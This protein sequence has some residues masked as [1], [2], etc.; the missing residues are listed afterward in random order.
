MKIITYLTQNLD[1]YCKHWDLS[2]ASDRKLFRT[3]ATEKLVKFTKQT[4]KLES[5]LA[6]FLVVSW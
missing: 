6:Y 5:T 4:N 1:K 3:P 2:A